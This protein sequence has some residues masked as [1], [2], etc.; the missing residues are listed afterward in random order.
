VLRQLK[1]ECG[2]ND[3][4]GYMGSLRGCRNL[5]NVK[6]VLRREGAYV[7][8]YRSA[9]ARAF[10]DGSVCGWWA[11]G[12][13]GGRCVGS[14]LWSGDGH[15][16]QL[17][18]ADLMGLASRD[19]GRD[20]SEA[21][22]FVCNVS[23]KRG[24][25]GKRGANLR[26]KSNEHV[27]RSVAVRRGELRGAPSSDEGGDAGGGVVC[28]GVDF[29]SVDVGVAA[30]DGVSADRGGIAADTG[31]SSSGLAVARGVGCLR[32]FNSSS[33]ES[34]GRATACL[35]LALVSWLWLLL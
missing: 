25:P 34:G 3:G 31:P 1:L 26:G 13:I 35:R 9:S 30:R 27:M 21:P 33:S 4:S 22:W 32:G 15:A 14:L 8:V 20:D 2:N 19:S 7:R 11:M 10:A 24:K 23:G 5:D 18:G 28:R 17:L 12:S 6:A 29:P 16:Y